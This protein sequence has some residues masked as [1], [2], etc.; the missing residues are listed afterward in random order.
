MTEQSLCVS[1]LV[2]QA[3]AC[4]FCFLLRWFLA[5]VFQDEFSSGI[6]FCYIPLYDR[7]VDTEFGHLRAIRDDR[8][9]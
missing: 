5:V 6:P 4:C 7:A 1:L 9:A 8:I 3:L 2:F